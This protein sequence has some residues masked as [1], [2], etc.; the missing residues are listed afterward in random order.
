MGPLEV[1]VVRRAE[2]STAQ[3]SN[4]DAKM[5]LLCCGCFMVGVSCFLWGNARRVRWVGRGPT[6]R[7]CLCPKYN[8]PDGVSV[9]L[10]T[11]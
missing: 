5:L 6:G 9:A 1:G 7:F 8:G 2:A 3:I 4:A 10:C 11:F